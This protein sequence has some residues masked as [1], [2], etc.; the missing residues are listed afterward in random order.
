MSLTAL[1]TNTDVTMY[2]PK[3]LYYAFSYRCMRHNLCLLIKI[4]VLSLLCC[5]VFAM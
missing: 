1:N 4:Q 5:E 3:H 2:V